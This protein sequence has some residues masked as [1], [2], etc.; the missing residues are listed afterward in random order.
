MRLNKFKNQY[1]DVLSES[2]VLDEAS[3]VM[4]DLAKELFSAYKSLVR[5][6]NYNIKAYEAAFQDAIERIYP[7]NAWWDVVDLNIFMHLFEN[8][9]P[10]L[11]I[12]EILKNV[13][14]E[15]KGSLDEGAYKIYYKNRDT[16]DTGI[17]TVEADSEQEAEDIFNAYKLED[18]D[19]TGIINPEIKADRNHLA[20]LDGAKV[21]DELPKLGDEINGA[22]VVQIKQVGQ[23][24]GHD[25]YKVITADHNVTELSGERHREF[26]PYDYAVKSELN[27]AW[28][29]DRADNL[30]IALT[31]DYTESEFSFTTDD[32]EQ[33]DFIIDLL[34]RNG[35]ET[36]ITTVTDEDGNDEF[37]ISAY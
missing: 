33:K 7:D 3:K 1:E 10:E 35:Y 29:E 11:T 18:D 4:T 16:G 37:Y 5:D 34:S 20:R 28:T 17:E 22:T 2:L 24:H 25:F 12:T 6:G 19:I 36:D 8:R 32:K 27:E 21:V 14:P 31:D 26:I 23:K 30:L 13:K 9:D 15:F